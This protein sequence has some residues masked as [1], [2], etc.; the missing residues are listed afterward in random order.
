MISVEATFQVSQ[1]T[2]FMTVLTN[3]KFLFTLTFWCKLME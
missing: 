2:V 1:E 3:N